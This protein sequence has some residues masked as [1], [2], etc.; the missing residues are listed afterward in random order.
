VIAWFSLDRWL[1]VMWF[2]SPKPPPPPPPPPPPDESEA[3]K[4]A[5]EARR[6]ARQRRGR[7]ATVLTS[8]TGAP[9]GTSTEGGPQPQR[10]LGQ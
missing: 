9:L 4:A 8:P 10:T 6:R 1:G 2:S 3:E 7:G 5:G